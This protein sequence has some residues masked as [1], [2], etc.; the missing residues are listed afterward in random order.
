MKSHWNY[1]VMRIAHLDKNEEYGIFEVYYDA[2][3]NVEGWTENASRIY[4]DNLEEIK[5]TLDL[6]SRALNKPIL[7]YKSGKEIK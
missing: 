7:D 1:R 3:G 4:T 5:R 6:M 2:N